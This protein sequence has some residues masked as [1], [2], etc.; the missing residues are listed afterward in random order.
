MSKSE[1]IKSSLI[2]TKENPY[3]NYGLYGLFLI[4][5]VFFTIT[6][7]GGEDDFFWH[8]ESGRFIVENKTIP[9]TDSFGYVTN[10]QH[11]IPF[12]WGWDVLTY[13]IFS[14]SGF[15][16][17]YIFRALIVLLIFFIFNRVL[18]KFKINVSLKLIFLIIFSWGILFRFG[19]RPHLITYLFFVLL[20]YIFSSY[21]Y[22]NRK[23]YKIL[24]FLPAIFCVWANFHMGVVAGFFLLSIYFGSEIII[25]FYPRKFSSKEIIPLNKPELKR[26]TVIYFLSLAALFI[27]PNHINTYL[28]VYSYT[29]FKYIY[30][31]GEW[32][33]PFSA[34]FST[35]PAMM[36]YK[37][38]L[39]AGIFALYYSI[40]KKDI[41]AFFVLAGFIA[42]SVRSAR[43]T[44]DYNILV[45]LYIFLGITLL[46]EKIKNTKIKHFIS[47][48]YI[49]K[50]VIAGIMIFQIISVQNDKLFNEYFTYYRKWGVGGDRYFLPQDMF[51]F[52]KSINL[53]ETGSHVFNTYTIGGLF[54][55]NFP[56]SKNFIDS[57]Y[58]NDEIYFEYDN[59]Q[60]GGQG[61]ADK[62]KKYDIDYFM[63]SYPNL[64]GA[65][66][67][68]NKT[69]AGYLS[70][71]SNEWKLVYWDDASMIFVKNIPKFEQIISKYEYKYISP[72]NYIFNKKLI[73]NAL[74]NDKQ[75]VE[76]EFKRKFDT[77]PQ[78]EIIN[79]INKSYPQK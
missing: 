10:G 29:G 21:K 62:I 27:N 75:T 78:G 2:S 76:N 55:Y 11:W 33:S 65:P 22:F 61:F 53:T 13:S 54:I 57:R 50:A 60:N 31:I 42:Y 1:T 14:T 37:F 63:L 32:Q 46:T 36:T 56:Q 41:Y 16:G 34:S 74:K 77:E 12:E 45:S 66:Q 23:N 72:F 6:K 40:K 69:I 28:Y 64:V 79:Y 20:I 49:F 8:V 38:L 5:L 59:I 26:L 19:L 25:Y 18:D 30:L 68:M 47:G 44:T 17:M 58:L 51:N 73:D 70:V 39:G 24:Y 7:I 35:S 71:K 48:S 52:A 15:L 43:F 3:V 4:L 9:V 67:D